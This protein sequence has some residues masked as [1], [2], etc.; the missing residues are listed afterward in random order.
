MPLAIGLRTA[1][2]ETD[3]RRVARALNWIADQLDQ[4]RS[5]EDTLLHSGKLLPRHISGLVL[6]AARTGTLGDAL[7]DLVE[8]EQSYRDL[9]RRVREGFAYPL[10]VMLLALAVLVLLFC[11]VT[12]PIGVMFDEFELRLPHAT[13]M[14]FWWRDTGVWVLGGA[15]LT[16]LGLAILYRLLAGEARWQYLLVTMP[17]FGRIWHATAIAEWSGLMS[18]VLKQ[19]IPLPDA[20]RLAAH[21]MRNRH[22][23]GISLK[24]A[25]GVAHGRPLSQMMFS[26]RSLP[27]TLIPLVEWGERQG[28]LAECFDVGREMFTKRA[29]VH[30]A[31]VRFL[32][33]PLM[34]VWIGGAVLFVL[35]ATFAPMIDLISKLS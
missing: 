21:G 23:A 26:Y 27:A 3:C 15:M 18:V 14:M 33:P 24:L 11:F 8:Q 16:V 2:E 29:T 1:A 35:G 32:L 25:D 13:Q 17:L 22:F 20:L 12:G 5:L 7:F 4:G 31:L 9:R 19:K 6:A 34:F 28:A 30:A 10:F